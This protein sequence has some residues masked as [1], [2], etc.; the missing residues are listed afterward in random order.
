MESNKKMVAGNRI[1]RGEILFTNIKIIS[2]GLGLGGRKLQITDF[3]EENYKKSIVTL[4]IRKE[5]F[6]TNAAKR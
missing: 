5:M 6:R 2:G 1:Y 4:E 3:H